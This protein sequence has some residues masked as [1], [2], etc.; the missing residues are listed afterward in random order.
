MAT[1]FEGKKGRLALMIRTDAKGR[2]FGSYTF[3]FDNPNGES[4]MIS[5]R[6]GVP[7]NFSKEKDLWY[8][9]DKDGGK[10]VASNGDRYLLSR[11]LTVD[12]S[13]DDSGEWPEVSFD[14]VELASVGVSEED[15]LALIGDEKES[16]PAKK[17]KKETSLPF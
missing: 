8:S 3:L 4:K 2:K 9:K 10:Y 7:S 1:Q 16:E 17:A 11:L 5:V 6:S 13:Y 12:G 15:I 14:K